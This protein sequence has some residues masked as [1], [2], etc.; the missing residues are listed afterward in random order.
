MSSN[1]KYKI[2]VKCNNFIVIGEEDVYFKNK[3]ENS[4]IL[5]TCRGRES[6]P[7]FYI[8]LRESHN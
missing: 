7:L 6:N 5:N 1:K 4:V 3:K 8:N 2:K